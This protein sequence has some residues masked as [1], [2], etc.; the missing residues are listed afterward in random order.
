MEGT[1]SNTID[2]EF[3]KSTKRHERWLKNLN[4]KNN[5]CGCMYCLINSPPFQNYSEINYD[6]CKIIDIF[7]NQLINILDFN[8]NE[9]QWGIDETDLW[10]SFSNVINSINNL[11]NKNEIYLKWILYTKYLH[12]NPMK[13][14]HYQI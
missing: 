14:D 12:W 13:D 4:Y 5:I 3:S 1:I 2:N 10:M 9:L 11:E 7:R 6:D 8:P